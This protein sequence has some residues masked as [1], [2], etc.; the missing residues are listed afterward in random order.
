MSPRM[1]PD[2]SQ[3]VIRKPPPLSVPVGHPRPARRP[4]LLGGPLVLN[5]K[6]FP[7]CLHLAIYKLISLH[8]P[9]SNLGH[10]RPCTFKNCR[11]VVVTTIVYGHVVGGIKRSN[12]RGTTHAAGHTTKHRHPDGGRSTTL[13]T[14]SN[15]FRDSPARIN[16]GHLDA[17]AYRAIDLLCLVQHNVILCSRQV[18]RR[19]EEVAG[20]ALSSFI[21][22]RALFPLLLEKE[23]RRKNLL[24]SRVSRCRR[25]RTQRQP[26]QP[27]TDKTP[28]AYDF[29]YRIRDESTSLGPPRH[30]APLRD[31]CVLA[32]P[33]ESDAPSPVITVPPR[34]N[35]TDS[36]AVT[37]GPSDILVAAPWRIV[38][39]V[40][41]G[42]S[43]A[44]SCESPWKSGDPFPSPIPDPWTPSESRPSSSISAERWFL[45][46]GLPLMC[47]MIFGGLAYMAC[48][49]PGE[50]EPESREVM[51]DRIERR[52]AARR[53]DSENLNVDSTEPPPP[54]TR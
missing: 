33:T 11:N 34:R 38:Y 37:L 19:R 29:T 20:H 15:V 9:F 2:L 53:R 8:T 1:C 44:P 26:S 25:G 17:S 6:T 43:C 45:Y 4:L 39:E 42:T 54:Y 35:E 3:P 47:V 24:L 23:T 48:R 32:H 36:V 13:H 50:K 21:H 22:E 16:R 31:I 46:I 30:D 27:L 18:P 51:M 52:R 28:R 7:F 14:A 12:G 5:T 10:K 49:R 40:V 41:D